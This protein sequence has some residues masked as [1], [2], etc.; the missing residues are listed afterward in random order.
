MRRC[1]STIA[2]SLKMSLRAIP[3][4]SATS[5]GRPSASVPRNR[6]PAASAM[7][8]PLASN[9]PAPFFLLPPGLV[10][11]RVFLGC[12]ELRHRNNENGYFTEESN[13]LAS[14]HE[15]KLPHAGRRPQGKAPRE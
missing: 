6:I 14:A 12:L 13:A 10:A 4:S 5:N 7:S 11:G 15:F 9:P 1:S 2:C 3:A 8:S